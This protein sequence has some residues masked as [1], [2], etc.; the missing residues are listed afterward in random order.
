[1]WQGESQ[2]A[3]VGAHLADKVTD[4]GEAHDARVAVTV[5]DEDVARR[6]HRHRGGLAEVPCVRSRLKLHTQG[7]ISLLL[8]P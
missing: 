3:H 5:G 8:A 2:L 4:G 6:C 7:D 1:M